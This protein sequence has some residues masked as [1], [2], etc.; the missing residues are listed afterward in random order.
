MYI[1]LVK[2]AQHGDKESL[3]RLAELAKERLY[4][5]VYRLTLTHE[6]TQDILQESMLEMFKFLDKLEKAEKFWPWLRRIAA[7][8][9]RSHYGRKQ[10]R[11]TM[12]LS[13]IDDKSLQQDSQEG[14]ADLIRQELKQTILS[15]MQA[16]FGAALLRTNEI[17][18]NW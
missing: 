18:G 9:V 10:N 8:K 11:S 16:Y 1:E 17:F 5:Y 3:N 4:A 14:V 15:A 2:R 6:L 12:S 13:E 7:N